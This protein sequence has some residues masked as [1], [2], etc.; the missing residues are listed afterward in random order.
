[1]NKP[2]LALS[3]QTS[4]SLRPRLVGI[5]VGLALTAT[6]CALDSSPEDDVQDDDTTALAAKPSTC[7]TTRFGDILPV[8]LD[9]KTLGAPVGSIPSAD[10]S[11]L[12]VID[13]SVLTCSYGVGIQIFDLGTQQ[14]EQIDRR[15][16]GIT[17]DGKHIWVNS[18]YD[19]TLSEYKSLKALRDDDASRTLPSAHATRLGAGEG[20]L[21][22]AWHSAAEVLDV[23][24]TT[25]ATTP[26]ALPGYDGWI[27]GLA[28]RGDRNY[29]VGGWV[30]MGIRAYDRTTGALA[31]TLFADEFLQGL[32][33][34]T[35]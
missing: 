2:Q 7:F 24:L 9:A 23:D 31:D 5:A 18:V 3:T 34:T 33:C 32:A 4:L 11:S 16:D 28:A 35:K 17:S 6:G 1:M 10:I 8:D 20:R 26:I 30:E 19:Q 14:V 25:G 21:L 29:V 15:C 27:F 13:N 12:G 22:A